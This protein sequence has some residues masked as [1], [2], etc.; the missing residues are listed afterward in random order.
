MISISSCTKEP[1]EKPSVQNTN[2]LTSE[3]DLYTETYVYEGKEYVLEYIGDNTDPENQDV[4]SEL[5]SLIEGKPVYLAR[6]SSDLS[7]RYIFTNSDETDIFL[8]GG[9]DYKR[10]PLP[11]DVSYSKG[12][13]TLRSIPPPCWWFYKDCGYNGEQLTAQLT[14]SQYYTTGFNNCTHWWAHNNL[15]YVPGQTFNGN[16]DDQ[17]SSWLGT[18]STCMGHNQPDVGIMKLAI[19]R[20]SDFPGWP[21]AREYISVE[22]ESFDSVECLK[23]ERWCFLGAKIND[24]ISSC[25][26]VICKNEC[27]Q[28]FDPT[29]G[30][31]YIK[32][33][34]D[35]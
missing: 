2:D 15:T 26:L 22:A 14:A 7:K 13:N 28:C 31:R 24:K 8:N 5:I 33:L 18:R 35:L 21:C 6:K 25:R 27:D 30:E 3:K 1:A 34:H 4:A 19:Y 23:S 11:K 9:Q 10:I 12:K 20:H 17:I 32:I 16:W 29:Y